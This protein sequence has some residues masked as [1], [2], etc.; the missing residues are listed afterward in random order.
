M[1]LT[2]GAKESVRERSGT[3]LSVKEREGGAAA[4]LMRSARWAGKEWAGE[5]KGKG[6]GVLGRGVSGRSLFF[7][8]P[9]FS[10]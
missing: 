2:G 1:L 4:W 10:I 3:R 7:F 9:S 6:K 5:R 8:I